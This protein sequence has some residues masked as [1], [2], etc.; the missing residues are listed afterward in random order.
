MGN[1]YTT[2]LV[3]TGRAP[4]FWML[5]AFAVTFAVTRGITRRIR[6]RAQA[7]GD[8]GKQKDGA[9]KDVIIGGVHIHHQVWGI[10][11][12]LVSGVV[13][14][15]YQPAS[16]WLEV[17]AILFG[18]GAALTLDEFALWLYL[19]DVY[20][21]DAGRKSVD[22]VVVAGAVIAATLLSSSPFGVEEQYMGP[23][24]MWVVPGLIVLNLV[25]VAICIAKGKLATGVIGTLIPI[26]SVV[27]ALRLAKPA[28][29]WAR[30]R[31]AARPR[32]AM[33]AAARAARD[34][35]LHTRFRDA[36]GGTPH[37]TPRPPDAE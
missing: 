1:W 8:M 13:A 20:W 19:E 3:D 7:A 12:L 31:Y 30:R 29:P 37:I 6:A 24:E 5:I 25:L 18:I 9:I 36:I 35:R 33:R 15:A 34:E 23:G 17:V 22:A 4:V 21:C 2:Y 10:S 32:L 28:S 26:F 11:L 16:P 27:G 14:F